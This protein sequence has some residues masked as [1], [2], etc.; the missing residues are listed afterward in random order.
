MEAGGTNMSFGCVEFGL[1]VEI[2]A[3]VVERAY[4]GR[5]MKSRFVR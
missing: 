3:S 2:R 4:R 5:K 1:G